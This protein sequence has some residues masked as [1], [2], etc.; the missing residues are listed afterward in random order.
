MENGSNAYLNVTGNNTLITGAYN[1]LSGSATIGNTRTLTVSGATS[2]SG[3]LNDFGTLT[4][5]G[6]LTVAGGG[7]VNI[8]NGTSGTQ[9]AATVTIAGGGLINLDQANGTLTQTQ[10]LTAAR[11]PGTKARA[12]PTP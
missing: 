4:T 6:G 2:V 12:S 5:T 9:A 11:S 8:G 10:F 1:L 3:T 7:V